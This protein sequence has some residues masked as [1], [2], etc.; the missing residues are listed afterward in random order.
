MNQNRRVILNLY[1]HKIK[2][3]RDMNYKYGKW[4]YSQYRPDSILE[5]YDYNRL[6]KMN[7]TKKLGHHLMNN[8]RCRYKLY[9]DIKDEEQVNHLIDNGFTMLRDMN[10]LKKLLI[11]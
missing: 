5:Y 11:K 4:D 7:R 6:K 1:R 8:I 9:S 3:C 2:I 10:N